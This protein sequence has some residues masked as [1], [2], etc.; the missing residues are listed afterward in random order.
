MIN[1]WTPKI[2]LIDIIKNV[3][4]FIVKCLERT[5]PILGN[6]LLYEYFEVERLFIFQN[7]QNFPVKFIREGQ[8]IQGMFVIVNQVEVILLEQTRFENSYSITD[9]IAMPEIQ[10]VQ[11]HKTKAICAMIE[12]KRG[13]GKFG[14]EFYSEDYEMLI[15]SLS[16]AMKE[17][18][19]V[20]SKSE[21]TESSD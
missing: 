14:V 18:A 11:K 13:G 5:G 19:T 12:I 8:L 17:S 2:T 20:N 3:P 21:A 16:G 4:S 15:S 6:P 1:E 10:S 7:V 9:F